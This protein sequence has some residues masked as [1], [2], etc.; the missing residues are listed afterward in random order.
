AAKSQCFR[1]GS[2]LVSISE[3]ST[4]ANYTTN[5]VSGSKPVL[6]HSEFMRGDRDPL[7]LEYGLSQHIG[8][9]LSAGTDLYQINGH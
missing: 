7:I 3:G 5:D 8:V 9:G 4:F 6:R 2:L 1:K